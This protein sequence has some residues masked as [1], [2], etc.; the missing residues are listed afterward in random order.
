MDSLGNSIRFPFCMKYRED[1][2]KHNKT[3]DAECN[4][5]PLE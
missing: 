4:L 1:R 3:L 2:A 5:F